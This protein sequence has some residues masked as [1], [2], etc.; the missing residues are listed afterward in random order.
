MVIK[1]K[2]KSRKRRGS[3]THGWG[4]G[5]KHRGAGHRG[6]RGFAGI[7]KRGA[8]K[9]TKYFAKG[10]KP[11]GKKGMKRSRRDQKIKSNP[12][13]LKTI[14]QKLNKWIANK[15]AIKEGEVFVVNL[16]KLGYT[17]VLGQGKLTKKLKLTCKKFSASAK[18]KLEE[19]GGEAS[20]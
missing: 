11:T 9:Q 16:T 4:A 10:I 5:K 19:A 8:Q 3:R 7:G 14:E 2:K 20:A 6:G 18:K 13:N 12:I 1:Q 17:A 15:K